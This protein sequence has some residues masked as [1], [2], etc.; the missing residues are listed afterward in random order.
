M[1]P[2]RER[3][4]PARPHRTV[5]EEEARLWRLFIDRAGIAPLRQQPGPSHAATT[6]APAERPAAAPDT[7]AER[8]AAP[9]A[10]PP[11][12]SI[13]TPPPG[14]DR[15]RWEDLRRGRTRPERT[16]DLHGQRAAN[17]YDTVHR[18]VVAA[19]AQ[20]LRCIAIVTGKGA[21]ESGGVLR[22]E[23]PHWLNGP[24]LRPMILAMVHPPRANTGA[25]HILLR[26][27]R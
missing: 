24:E 13:G 11:P 17:A 15:R 21:G 10:P 22:R 4:P 1:P 19:H 7:T 14:L 3:M 20:G 2:P 26:R 5:T 6:D 9:P 25:V 8:S 27:K 12:L 18:F 16:L 23:L